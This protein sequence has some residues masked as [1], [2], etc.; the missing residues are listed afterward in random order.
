M[1]DFFSEN[2][3]LIFNGIYLY[4]SRKHFICQGGAFTLLMFHAST[5]TRQPRRKQRESSSGREVEQAIL[6][7]WESLDYFCAQ[8]L[9]PVLLPTAGHLHRFGVLRISADRLGLQRTGP[10]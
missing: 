7:G 10:L 4:Y 2:V 9:T 1:F 6:L 8:R 3:Q 5:L